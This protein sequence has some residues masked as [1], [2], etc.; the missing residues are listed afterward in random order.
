MF[1][2]GTARRRAF[3]HPTGLQHLARVHDAE[4]IEHRL[5]A[6]HQF[7]CGLVL[8]RRQFVALQNADAMFGGDRAAQILNDR[9]R[10]IG[11]VNLG[12]KMMGN[13]R[14][15]LFKDHHLRT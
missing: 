1:L 3:A 2:V 4:R 5:D 7:D 6:A 12:A 10:P 14:K 8:D 11:A 13:S 15:G 9:E